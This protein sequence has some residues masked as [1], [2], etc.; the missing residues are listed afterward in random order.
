MMA[1][2]KTKTNGTKPWT[3]QQELSV[4]TSIIPSAKI[5]LRYVATWSE[6]GLNSRRVLP[7]NCLTKTI[8]CSCLRHRDME[9][10][11][12]PCQRCRPLLSSAV[13]NCSDPGLVENGVRQSG[14]RYPEVFS[15]GVA[16]AIHCKRGFY[17]LGSALLTCQ[18][19]GRWDR[20]IPRCLG[21]HAWAWFHFFFL[22]P[23]DWKCLWTGYNP[24]TLK[25]CRRTSTKLSHAAR[26]EQQQDSIYFSLYL[27]E[28]AIWGVSRATGRKMRR[29]WETERVWK[30][31]GV[32]IK[33]GWEE[34]LKVWSMFASA[35]MWVQT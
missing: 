6:S 4:H 34:R 22:F 35:F 29:E 16:V 13:V 12:C 30:W 23:T 3:E 33:G 21:T 1:P 24:R 10:L 7:V 18:H 19:D 11:G 26:K 8:H 2:Q 28:K 32:I 17:L 9:A 5:H 20:P 31:E 25:V 27:S 14:L 15:Y